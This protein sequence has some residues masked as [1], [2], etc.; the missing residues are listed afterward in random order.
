M[1]FSHGIYVHH[2]LLG[3]IRFSFFS[4]GNIIVFAFYLAGVIEVPIFINR[5]T[6]IFFFN[7]G[8]HFCI[9]LFPKGFGT[10]HH[11]IVIAI[12]GLQVTHY[13][14][15][16]SSFFKI[17]VHPEIIINSCIAMRCQGFRFFICHGRCYIFWPFITHI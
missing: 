15:A 13:I 7:A 10:R 12:F 2:N 3:C 8:F 1:P 9:Q 5:H 6:F 11:R 14:A 4:A 17:I 16:V